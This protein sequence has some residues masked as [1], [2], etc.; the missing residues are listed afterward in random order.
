MPLLP[1]LSQF[2]CK[3]FLPHHLPVVQ[4][5]HQSTALAATPWHVYYMNQYNYYKPL[6]EFWGGT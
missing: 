1:L 3:L 6:Y 5:L 4:D 2:L